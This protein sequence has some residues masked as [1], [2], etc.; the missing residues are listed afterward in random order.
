[1][2]ITTIRKAFVR[3]WVYY[4]MLLAVPL[5]YNKIGYGKITALPIWSIK[6]GYLYIGVFVLMLITLGWVS[7]VVENTVHPPDVQSFGSRMLRIFY[8]P[9]VVLLGLV[10]L[11]VYNIGIHHREPQLAE[12]LIENARYRFSFYTV[13]VLAYGYW[14]LQ[15]EK[16]KCAMRELLHHRQVDRAPRQQRDVDTKLVEAE[17]VKDVPEQP[18]LMI[19]ANGVEEIKE[20]MMDLL[21]PLVKRIQEGT[22]G[23][24]QVDSQPDYPSQQSALVNSATYHSLMERH[25]KILYNDLGQIIF[26]NIIIIEFKRREVHL[27]LIDG[28]IIICHGMKKELEKHGLFRWLLRVRRSTYVNMMHVDLKDHSRK[29][30]NQLKLQVDTEQRMMKGHLEAKLLA[31]LLTFG[32][33]IGLDN[34]NA[35]LKESP[36]ASFDGW[37]TFITVK[38]KAAMGPEENGEK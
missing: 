34:L 38:R 17:V 11:L 35:F 14:R 18:S 10:L 4:L 12:I 29:H 23:Q 8:Y 7:L 13:V 20:V 24:E 37:D 16:R 36:E 5:V 31:Q 21:E 9:I 26:F 6:F 30:S 19:T 1:M 3:N 33:E 15:R 28:T 2:P 25:H 27:Y 32:S 22:A